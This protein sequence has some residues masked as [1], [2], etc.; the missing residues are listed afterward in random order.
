MNFGLRWEPE[1]LK[2]L[3]DIYG[4][5]EVADA[6]IAAVDWQLSQNPLRYTWPLRPGHS[7]LLVHIKPYLEHPAVAI[8]FSIVQDPPDRYC[9]MMR[10]RRTA[11]NDPLTS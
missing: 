4:D 6:A 9:L 5:L 10:A 7:I 3:E 8:S 1:C 2:D 11:R